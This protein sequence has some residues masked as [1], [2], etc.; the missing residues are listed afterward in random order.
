MLQ[1]EESDEFSI[2]A[3][4]DKDFTIKMTT[5]VNN[6]VSFYPSDTLSLF[7]PR[8]EI[9]FKLT[10]LRTGLIKIRYTL[11]G[12][13]SFVFDQPED[14]IIYVFPSKNVKRLSNIPGQKFMKGA[15]NNLDVDKCM[16]G[17]N[18][19]LSSTCK[20]HASGTFGYVNVNIGNISLPLSMTG[21][22]FAASEGVKQFSNNGALTV[23]KLT[24]EMLTTGKKPCPAGSCLN[25]GYTNADNEFILKRN[26]FVRSFYNSV[27]D[28]NPWW[29]TCNLPVDYEGFHVND[30][31]SLLLRAHKM[32]ELRNGNCPNI[33]SNLEGTFSALVTRAP[34][35]IDI[36]GQSTRFDSSFS[37]CIVLDLCSRVSYISLP[38]DKHLDAAPAISSLDVHIKGF[39]FSDAKFQK[40]MCVHFWNGVSMQDNNF[41]VKAKLWSKVSMHFDAINAKLKFQ[42]ELF[43]EPNSLDNVSSYC[44]LND[45][46][47]YRCQ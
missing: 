24:Q 9:V 43:A 29:I 32:K 38:A 21:V 28:L 14:G 35:N 15:C 12:K 19:L 40:E 23:S 1:G 39:G 30:I 37:T 44:C 3:K 22:N 31:Q 11:Y 34:V 25:T 36:M 4:P 41:C 5:V 33:P 47:I 2:R 16:D 42:G 10:P 6:S 26:N 8:E 18:I 20:W 46:F 17:S 45:Q 13:D 7:N 27:S